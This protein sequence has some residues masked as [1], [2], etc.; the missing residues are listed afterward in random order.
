MEAPTDA[1][2][3]TQPE[4]SAA[5]AEGAEEPQDPQEDDENEVL[6]AKAQS[7]ID[8]ITAHPE[9][10]SPNVLHA[11]AT[12]LETQESRYSL[13]CAAYCSVSI[14]KCYCFHFL[15]GIFFWV[16]A[17]TGCELVGI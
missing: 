16:K 10:P 1:E 8:R 7:L 6:M 12:I 5:V 13:F 17:S 11:L 9:N 3:Q 14:K 4:P 2:P 15:L